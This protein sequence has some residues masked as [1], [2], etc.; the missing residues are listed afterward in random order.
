MSGTGV[1]DNSAP[2]VLTPMIPDQPIGNTRAGEQVYPSFWFSQTLLRILAY[3]GQPNGS[4]STVSQQISNIGDIITNNTTNNSSS[5]TIASVAA[6][7][8]QEET[9]PLPLPPFP[10][11]EELTLP[12]VMARVAIGF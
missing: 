1:P 9:G 5:S 11:N 7:L 12:A 6:L 4:G 8:A 10:P 3:L 2:T